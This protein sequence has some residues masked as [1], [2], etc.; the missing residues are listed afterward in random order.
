VPPGAAEVLYVPQQPVP[1]A[2]ADAGEA[3][4]VVPQPGVGVE[5]GRGGRQAS[6]SSG[7]S[8]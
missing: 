5:S 1:V 2:V 3:V 7:M 4:A 8:A 6:P